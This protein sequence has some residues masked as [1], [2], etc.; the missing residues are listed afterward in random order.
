MLLEHVPSRLLVCFGFERA[1]EC[2][3]DLRLCFA[4]A[5]FFLVEALTVTLGVGVGAALVTGDRRKADG[6]G[7]VIVAIELQK[8]TQV[9]MRRM[10]WLISCRKRKMAIV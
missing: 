4:T 5:D 9:Q 7:I 2:A 10:L 8:R 3:A 1:P 6:E